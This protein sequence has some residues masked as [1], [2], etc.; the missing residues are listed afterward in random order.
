MR[1]E[2]G[3]SS[4]TTT[5][6]IPTLPQSSGNTQLILTHS[7]WG[8]TAGTMTLFLSVGARWTERVASRPSL[9]PVFYDSEAGSACRKS[10]K[11]RAPDAR[12]WLQD[13]EGLDSGSTDR[14][15]GN[16]GTEQEESQ[17]VGHIS[18]LLSLWACRQLN[19]ASAQSPSPLI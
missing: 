9:D 18:V 5:M 10:G 4:S 2:A 12:V 7:L 6:R 11:Q 14:L 16:E 8:H 3:S 13:T 17:D 15:R 1:P 19:Q